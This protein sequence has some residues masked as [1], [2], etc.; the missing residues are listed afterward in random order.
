MRDVV[1]VSS[2]RYTVDTPQFRAFVSRLVG[3][4]RT[5]GKVITARSYLSGGRA[6]VSADG[7]ATLIR[8]LV[9]SD[10]DIK[11][12]LPIVKQASRTPGFDVAITG[13]HTV[14]NDFTTLSQRDLEHGELAFGL[15]AA[16]VVLM[17]VFG[18]VVAGLVPVLMALLSIVV[19]LGLVAMLSLEFTCRSSS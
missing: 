16:L 12:I 3:E 19:G 4:R 6:L 10:S 15:P 9:A 7:H 2:T 1:V 14:G 17:L 18:A 11:P 13:E 5:T 8:L